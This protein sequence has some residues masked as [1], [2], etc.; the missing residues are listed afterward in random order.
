MGKELSEL[1]RNISQNLKALISGNSVGREISHVR[2][3]ESRE[4][5]SLWEGLKKPRQGVLVK[6]DIGM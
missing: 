5:K 2:K 4:K 1:E 3:E 6:L